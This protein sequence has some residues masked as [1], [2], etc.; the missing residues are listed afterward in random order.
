[1]ENFYGK[2]IRLILNS[3]LEETPTA[4]EL[5]WGLFEK[6][7]IQPHRIRFSAF[8]T[9]REDY[10]VSSDSKQVFFW[11]PKEILYK[12]PINA[13]ALVYVPEI[14]HVIA[15][16]KG[17]PYLHYIWMHDHPADNVH[18]TKFSNRVVTTLF[19]FEKS[20]ILVGAGQGLLFT[21]LT[22][23]K[24]NLKGCSPGNIEMNK[25]NELFLDDIF[26]LVDAPLFIQSQEMIVVPR[27]TSLM[28]L[29]PEGKTIRQMDNVTKAKITSLTYYDLKIVVGDEQGNI[30]IIDTKS[31]YSRRRI[32]IGATHILYASLFDNHF[33]VTVS[34]NHQINLYSL[35]SEQVISSFELKGEPYTCRQSGNLLLLFQPMTI[36]C[37]EVNIC[38]KYLAG[39]SS[40]ASSLARSPYEKCIDCLTGDDNLI[41]VKNKSTL[42]SVR[43][44]NV[45]HLF[46]G[47]NCINVLTSDME[48]FSVVK[49]NIVPFRTLSSYVFESAF[50][51]NSNLDGALL[52][53]GHLLLYDSQKKS[54][55]SS[56]YIGKYKFICGAGHLNLAILSC[57]DKLIGFD[58]KNGKITNEIDGTMYVVMKV[59]ANTLIAGCSNGCIET[60]DLPS[61]D[62]RVNSQQHNA[63]H[64]DNGSTITTRHYK[65]ALF[66]VKTI[67]YLESKNMILSMS[68]NGEIF[69]WTIDLW[70]VIHINMDFG[71]TAACFY[72]NSGTVLISAF[73]SL[74]TIG[75]KYIFGKNC[76]DEEDEGEES[77]IKREKRKLIKPPIE[78]KASAYRYEPPENQKFVFIKERDDEE[79][80]PYEIPSQFKIFDEFEKIDP[81]PFQDLVVDEEFIP[82]KHFVVNKRPPPTFTLQGI[83]IVAR[84][85]IEDVIKESENKKKQPQEPKKVTV[86]PPPIPPPKKKSSCRTKKTSKSVSKAET[87][88]SELLYPPKSESNK[89]NLNQ[90]T[91]AR[92]KKKPGYNPF[93]SMIM[94]K[95]TDGKFFSLDNDEEM[96]TIQFD[97]P[98]EPE[99]LD[100]EIGNNSFV[101][102]LP[103]EFSLPKKRTSTY[104]EIVPRPFSFES[105]PPRKYEIHTDDHDEDKKKEEEEEERCSTYWKN[106]NA[107]F[108]EPKFDEGHIGEVT[109]EEFNE[110]LKR[111]TIIITQ[112][113]KKAPKKLFSQS[114]KPKMTFKDS[115]AQ[116]SLRRVRVR[117]CSNNYE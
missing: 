68:Q 23:P 37:Y 86:R 47:E 14:D 74:F 15:Y 63:H 44:D 21:K 66:C 89:M 105:R 13:V 71:V 106:I 27:N 116:N 36:F 82:K 96:P 45:I 26:S 19:F 41:K 5:N 75:A 80:E 25:V 9:I 6:D 93:R 79:E 20:R 46:Y 90:S 17:S 33:M 91:S 53:T 31:N 88:P 99:P 117:K 112:K 111:H 24:I 60:R 76:Y 39:I 95:E 84:P 98:E 35:I 115:I 32:N 22:F 59:V 50:H 1:M 55:I 102:K 62:F 61:L 107:K 42:D 28:L 69:I 8:C 73:N 52:D 81:G 78:R 18:P 34:L 70:P 72:N 77:K 100:Y 4:A 30:L 12:L 56:H 109:M 43:L 65:D 110:S 85:D 54:V 2:T 38:T 51:I 67:D 87:K 97:E 48:F 92:R 49:R 3:M 108:I 11:T 10:F 40:N 83:K 94:Q 113:P 104:H 58:T 7:I 57:E 101:V 16:V 103:D 64:T 29:T 114:L